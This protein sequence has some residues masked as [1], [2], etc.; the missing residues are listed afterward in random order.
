MLVYCLYYYQEDGPEDLLVDFD[1]IRFRKRAAA[2]FTQLMSKIP[3]SESAPQA[4]EMLG[5][6]EAAIV[7][8]V[9]VHRLQPV[10][11]AATVEI[12]NVPGC[13]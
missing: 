1:A 6:L 7:A 13:D 8:G 3:E 12:V 2:W 4:A 10:W 11:G 5:R 9:G